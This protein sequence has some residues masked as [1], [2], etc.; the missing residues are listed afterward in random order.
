[1]KFNF[2]ESFG[3]LKLALRKNGLI[4]FIKMLWSDVLYDYRYGVDTYS[5]IAR[6]DLFDGKRLKLQNRYIPSTFAI[7][8]HTIREES[9]K[10]KGS[11]VRSNS[12]PRRKKGIGQKARSEC[13][14]VCVKTETGL[15]PNAQM[16]PTAAAQPS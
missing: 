10:S 7:I 12:P 2:S 4:G 13:L 1:M 5:P 6:E 11:M 16:F 15:I 9:G 8:E 3:V 14:I